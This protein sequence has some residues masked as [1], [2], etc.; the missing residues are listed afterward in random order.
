MQVDSIDR[1]LMNRRLDLREAIEQPPRAR[2][3]GARQRRP[4][5]VAGDIV[6]A[7]E[8]APDSEE[9]GAGPAL[10]GALEA[11]WIGEEDA[12]SWSALEEEEL[13]ELDG[14]SG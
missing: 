13:D 6:P 8:V 12:P 4:I 11:G 10:A 5:D 7:P 2:L 3:P 14:M 9:V 1:H